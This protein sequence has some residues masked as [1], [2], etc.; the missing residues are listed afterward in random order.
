M[1]IVKSK[2]K[3]NTIKIPNNSSKL[4]RLLRNMHRHWQLYILLIPTIVFF[5]VF[6]YVPM[7]GVQIAFRDFSIIDGFTG[8]EWVGLKH[9]ERFVSS[10][11]FWLVL[12]NTI[13]LSLMQL[14]ISFPLPI[15]ISLLLNQLKKQR[16]KTVIQNILIAPHF[17]SLVV[18]IGMVTIF[19]NPYTG[20][21]N[22]LIEFF[23]GEAVFFLGEPDYFKPIY[24]L[25]GVWQSTGWGTVVYVAA[26]SSIDPTLYEAA[27]VDG[28]SR[29]QK[30]WNIDFHGILPVIIVQLILNTG[31][32]LSIGYEKILLLQNDLNRVASE[33]I[34]TYEFKQ[35]VLDAQFSYSSAIGLFNAVI[36]LIILLTVNYL[37]K[38]YSETSIL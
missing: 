8:S 36:N 9:F 10:P 29:W 14:I 4:S 32:M 11:D 19:L 15:F 2:T 35:G 13:S 20:I 34:S 25:S 1:D 37:A 24:V 18:L 5:I 7:Y 21:L 12:K 27:T 26:L 38:K 17:I 28:A 3:P 30:I 31:Q 6:K 33:V 23:G 16:H 22:Q